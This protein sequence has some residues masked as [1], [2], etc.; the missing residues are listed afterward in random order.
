MKNNTVIVFLIYL[1][2]LTES[3]ENENPW[4]KIVSYPRAATRKTLGLQRLTGE[5]Y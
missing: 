1:G 2:S 5:F 3:K 4:R